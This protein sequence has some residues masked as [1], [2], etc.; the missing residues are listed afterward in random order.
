MYGEEIPNLH[1]SYQAT[2]PKE[3]TMNTNSHM[4]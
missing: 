2:A 1:T 3:E 4:T